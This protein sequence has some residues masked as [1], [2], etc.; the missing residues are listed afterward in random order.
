MHSPPYS[1]S[2]RRYH[3]EDYSSWPGTV[4]VF[5]SNEAGRHGRGAARFALEQCG[6]VYGKGR[7][8]HGRSFA[9]PTKD[10]DIL[11]LPLGTVESNVRSFIIVANESMDTTFFVTRVGCGLAGYTDAQ[12]APLFR[13]APY[14]CILP[15][16]WQAYLEP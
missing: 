16:A 11:P 13:K 5:G 12:I 8:L 14:N 3:D 6:A 2:G 10:R 15:R 9:L 1:P 4:F 7:G